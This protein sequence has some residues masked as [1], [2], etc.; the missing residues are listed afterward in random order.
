L[1]SSP[2]VIRQIKSR[3]VKWAGHV[4]RMGE[5]RNVY[6]ILMGKPEGKRPLERPMRRG[7][8]EIRVDRRDVGGGE[9]GMDSAGSGLGLVTGS[10]EC[11]DEPS[12]S[13]AT[14]LVSFSE[15]TLP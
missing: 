12:G 3:R 2:D 1:Y 10:S 13:G 8:D 15:I 7:E 11:G 6:R 5:G 14:D 9:C 4:A